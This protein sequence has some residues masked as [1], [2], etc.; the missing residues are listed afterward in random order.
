MPEVD[1]LTARATPVYREIRKRAKMNGRLTKPIEPEKL[2][3]LVAE[4]SVE[5]RPQIAATLS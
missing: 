5:P 1:G 4:L 2:R 3:N